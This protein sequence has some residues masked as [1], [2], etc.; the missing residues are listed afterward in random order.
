MFVFDLGSLL[1]EGIDEHKTQ[2]FALLK[3]VALPC[4]CPAGRERTFGGKPAPKGKGRAEITIK[5][6]IK[7]IFLRARLHIS[8]FCCNF[9]ADFEKRTG[10]L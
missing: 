6:D 2:G 4:V 3:F 1:T 7:K 10:N 5:I 8:I 9:A